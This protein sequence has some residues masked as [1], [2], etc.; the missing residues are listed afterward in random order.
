MMDASAHCIPCRKGDKG[1]EPEAL[2]AALAALPDW[3]VVEDGKAIR[4]RFTFKNF[5]QALHFVNEVATI[6]EQEDHHPDIQFGWGYA[7]IAFTTHA[8]GG[9]HPN[10]IVMAHKVNAIST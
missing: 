1:L 4:R 7:E 3:Q 2:Q 8:I 9:L 6:A 10:D 5:A